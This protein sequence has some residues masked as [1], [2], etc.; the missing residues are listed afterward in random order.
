MATKQEIIDAAE[1]A[2]RNGG[3]VEGNPFGVDELEAQ[4]LWLLAFNYK[5]AEIEAG[6]AS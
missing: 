2:A 3:N 5:R 4:A 1:A 6:T